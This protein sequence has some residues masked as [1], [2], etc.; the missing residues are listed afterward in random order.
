MDSSRYVPLSCLCCLLFLLPDTATQT[1]TGKWEMQR[2]L[3]TLQLTRSNCVGRG[4]PTQS[5]TAGAVSQMGFRRMFAI[6]HDRM[7]NTRDT[8]Q[9]V[10]GSLSIFLCVTF[11]E[12]MMPVFVAFFF[13]HHMC[14]WR[15]FLQTKW[16]HPGEGAILTSLARRERKIT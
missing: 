7:K 16:R 6:L 8:N 9:A 1:M 13:F 10:N 12:L 2:S 5:L 14:V 3:S 11:L 15:T 4:L